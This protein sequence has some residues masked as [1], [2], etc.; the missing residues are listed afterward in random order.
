MILCAVLID[1]ATETTIK[2]H[3]TV[4]LMEWPF[5]PPWQIACVQ[6]VQYDGEKRLH[7]TLTV[8]GGA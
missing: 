4:A 1:Y 5:G 8:G 2:T 7:E 3:H 6:T